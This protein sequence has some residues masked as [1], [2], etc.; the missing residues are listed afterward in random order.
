MEGEAGSCGACGL[1]P[2]KSVS[3]VPERK[4]RLQ[5][6]EDVI[7]E[8]LGVADLL[9]AGPAGGLEAG[10]GEFLA[11]DL[12]RHAVLQGE[13]DGGGEGVHQAG[14]GGAF[15]GHLDEDF[16]RLAVGVEADGDVALV[17]GDGEFVGDGGALVGQAMADGARRTVE[18][19]RVA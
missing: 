4:R 6:A 7:H 14:D 18:V 17:A 9:V 8:A 3:C 16:A 1:S 15:L 12:E 13:R 5:P 11:E 2:A 10:V 19:L